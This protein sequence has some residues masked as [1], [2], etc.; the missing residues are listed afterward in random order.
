MRLRSV[1]I[2]TV[3]GCVAAALP[4]TCYPNAERSAGVAA[5]ACPRTPAVDGTQVANGPPRREARREGY[6]SRQTVRYVSSDLFLGDIL[7]LHDSTQEVTMR[8]K[9]FW[10]GP[11]DQERVWL[12]RYKSASSGSTC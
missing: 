10:I 3:I 8:W 5:P 7:L 11:V 12:R 6:R 9:A 4:I 1:G 2:G